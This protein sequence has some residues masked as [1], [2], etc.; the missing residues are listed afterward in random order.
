M[1]Y[2]LSQLQNEK[3]LREAAGA[4]LDKLGRPDYRPLPVIA[5]EL[6]RKISLFQLVE[7]V[8]VYKGLGTETIDAVKLGIVYE[9]YLAMTTLDKSIVCLIALGVCKPDEP[10]GKD[11]EE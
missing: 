5:E 6:F 4:V 11:G 8:C 2:T 10:A 3:T 7:A 9:C 1:T